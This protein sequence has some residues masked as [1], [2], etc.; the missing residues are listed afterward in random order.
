MFLL[1]QCHGD[2]E[3]NPGP[4]KLKNKSISVCHW[5]LN[6]LPAHNFSKLTQ[7]RAYISMYSINTISYAYQKLTWIPQYLIVCSK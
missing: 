4:R 6:S 1:L 5:N 2:I 3:K 7:L